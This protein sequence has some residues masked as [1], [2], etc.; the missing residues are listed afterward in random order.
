MFENRAAWGCFTTYFPYK[1]T[2]TMEF[3]GNWELFS[4]VTVVEGNGQQAK[5]GV[6]LSFLIFEAG[7][8]KIY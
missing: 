4:A 7:W 6:R 5:R 2:A 3:R 8:G 1:M